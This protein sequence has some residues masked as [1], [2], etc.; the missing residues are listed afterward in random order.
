MANCKCSL[1]E[2]DGVRKWWYTRDGDSKIR[3]T[4]SKTEVNALRVGELILEKL[5]IA[6][7]DRRFYH[8][9]VQ[10]AV[11]QQLRMQERYFTAVECLK[12]CKE[13]TSMSVCKRIM[14]EMSDLKVEKMSYV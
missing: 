5:R 4:I 6:I 13:G 1:S 11:R 7:W 2:T 3:L 10:M 14:L 12:S 9:E 8:E